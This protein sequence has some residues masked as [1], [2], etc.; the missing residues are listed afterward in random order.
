MNKNVEL[1]TIKGRRAIIVEDRNT[2][3]CVISNVKFGG[4]II[5]NKSKRKAM[6]IWSDAMD[7]A[8]CVQKLLQLSN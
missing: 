5:R 2:G 7:M 6:K 4:A 8:E 1:L 3:E